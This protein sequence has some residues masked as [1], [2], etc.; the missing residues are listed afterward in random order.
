[1]HVSTDIGGTFTDFVVLEEG[2]LKT[3]KLPS[4]PKNPSLAVKKGLVRFEK[5]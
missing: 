2:E 1:M 5:V 3:F 4:T